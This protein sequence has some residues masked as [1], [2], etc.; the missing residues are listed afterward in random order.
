VPANV[1]V[2]IA[3]T[4]EVQ[5][6]RDARSHVIARALREGQIVYDGR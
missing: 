1:D 2:L 5:F 4:D 6:W 3:S